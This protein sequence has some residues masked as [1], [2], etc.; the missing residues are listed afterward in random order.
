M[1]AS[2]I[3]NLEQENTNSIILLREGIF[4][5]AYEK[6]AYAFHREVHPYKLSCKYVRVVKQK[7]VS[8]GF[9]IA[10][11]TTI[12]SGK[13]VLLHEEQRLI[14]AAGPIDESDFIAWKQLIP[15]TG[16]KA[17]H[18]SFS[19]QVHLW[20]QSVEEF[21]G[22]EKESKDQYLKIANSIREFNIESK[23]PLEC[24]NFIAELNQIL[25]KI[26]KE[27]KRG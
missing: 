2:E 7:M 1:T 4:W 22:T 15:V 23:T 5:K 14:L 6:S 21:Y 10:A 19:D 9:P 11:T 18:V 24:M 16:S 27:V 8:L 13:N 26:S 17:K 20:A 3:M 25:T 12:I